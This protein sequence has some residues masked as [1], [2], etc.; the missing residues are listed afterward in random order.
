M[1]VTAVDCSSG[2]SA[3][4]YKFEES[5]GYQT[6]KTYTYS[7]PGQY[8]V[9]QKGN[10]TCGDLLGTKFST[11][12]PITVKPV[13]KPI[14]STKPC[15]DSKALV[16]AN[17]PQYDTYKLSINSS[18]EVSVLKNQTVAWQMSSILP[19]TLEVQ[20][21]YNEAN[22]GGKGSLVVGSYTNLQSP[23]V[24]EIN[25]LNSSQVN[26]KFQAV[27]NQL[28]EIRKRTGSSGN[29]EVVEVLENL[30]GLQTYV[31]NNLNTMAN[32]Y[33]FQVRTFDYCGLKE[34]LSGEYCTILLSGLVQNKKNT[35]QWNADFSLLANN[36]QLSINNQ[37][38]NSFST[39]PIKNSFEDANVVCGKEYCY[40]ITGLYADNVQTKSLPLCLKASSTDTPP[41]VTEISSSVFDNRIQLQWPLPLAGVKNYTL[42]VST[43]KTN[44]SFFSNTF[45]NTFENK[46]HDPSFKQYCYKVAYTDN[47]GNTSDF[48][49]STCHI[50]LTGNQPDV[51]TR[52]L[53]WQAYEGW[54]EGVQEYLVEKLDE[55]GKVYFSQSVAKNLDYSE[56][57]LD[58]NEQIIHFRVK[59]ISNSGRVSYSNYF[60]VRQKGE[61]YMPNAFTPNGDGLND[62]CH[63]EGLF[64]K[65][66]SLE[67]WDKNGAGV[68]ATNSFKQGWDGKING[69][70]APPDVYMYRAEAVDKLGFVYKLSG[71]IQLIK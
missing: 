41:A 32:T 43:N 42:T 64:I 16:L 20:G 15:A 50:Y 36:Y 60:E 51:S 65:D 4:S 70:P 39:R 2:G 35:I 69:L 11:P 1:D 49:P 19:E 71:T 52:T 26:I 14:L 44:F 54:P 38:A 34:L 57:G 6:S 53:A 27:P 24:T 13:P 28:Y 68:F 63:A 3:L 48:S 21:L 55:S 67:I 29:F 25:L 59:G 22:C 8:Q 33:C 40:Q 66:F 23:V 17:D 12:V 7:I 46:V 58:T 56:K 62:I 47:C 10:F 45:S 5:L 31:F 37:L 30:Q 18:S 9:I 61:F